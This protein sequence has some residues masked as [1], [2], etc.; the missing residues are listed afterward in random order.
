MCLS[1]CLCQF[2][3][4]CECFCVSVTLCGFVSLCV[5]PIG[6]LWISGGLGTVGLHGLRGIF[7]P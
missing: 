2:F 7:H 5:F 6:V 3:C 1:V 4:M